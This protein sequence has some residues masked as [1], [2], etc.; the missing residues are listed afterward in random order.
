M[1]RLGASCDWSRERFTLDEQLSRK[2]SLSL[3]T[4]LFQLSSE[5][6]LNRCS[7]QEDMF[8]HIFFLLPYCSVKAL[9][10]LS[11]KW[12]LNYIR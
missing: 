3:L 7:V 4:F 8:R 1:K 12:F 10:V 2:D 6:V 11:L 5:T 9:L